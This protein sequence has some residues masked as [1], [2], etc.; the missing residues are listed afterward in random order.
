MSKAGS[1]SHA[2]LLLGLHALRLL[3]M[4]LWRV[5]RSRLSA[6]SQYEIASSRSE[7]RV[8]V[9]PGHSNATTS[10]GKIRDSSLYRR[11]QGTRAHDSWHRL[12]VSRGTEVMVT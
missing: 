7:R 3:S 11:G 5:Q 8:N 4:L 10:A 1:I 9:T 12:C 6:L 2:T